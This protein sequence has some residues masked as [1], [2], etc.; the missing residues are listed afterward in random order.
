MAVKRIR[1][2]NIIEL[3]KM[4]QHAHIVLVKKIQA[5][6]LRAGKSS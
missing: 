3:L 4:K 2:S 1:Q 5:V 6:G